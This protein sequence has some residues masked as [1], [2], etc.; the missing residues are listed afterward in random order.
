MWVSAQ[1]RAQY[2]PAGR[3]LGMFGVVQDVTEKKRLEQ[4][5]R[6]RA[7]E[8]AE[9][10]RK[11]DDFIALLAHELRNPL[12][13]IRNGLQVMRLAAGDPGAVAERPRA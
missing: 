2:D 5:L 12:A 11:K 13:P 4:E 10:D 8:L 1:G 3:A 6:Q 9:A 7:D